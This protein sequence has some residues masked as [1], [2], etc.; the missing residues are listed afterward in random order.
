MVYPRLKTFQLTDFA[1]TSNPSDRRKRV[2][3]PSVQPLSFICRFRLW[4]CDVAFSFL[5]ISSSNVTEKSKLKKI[6]RRTTQRRT[7]TRNIGDVFIRNVECD[8]SPLSCVL[9]VEISNASLETKDECLISQH[10]KS[11]FMNEQT[12]K[13]VCTNMCA[14]VN[15]EAPTILWLLLPNRSNVSSFLRS[16]QFIL[17]C[18]GCFETFQNCACAFEL[19][20]SFEK[21]T[22]H[23]TNERPVN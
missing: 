4:C 5:R 21:Q 3:C 16:I 2:E 12:N 18:S 10:Y 23:Q 14:G 9:Y 15:L 7:L 22:V 8:S 13:T 19:L 6:Q 20:T 17:F 1:P 11:L